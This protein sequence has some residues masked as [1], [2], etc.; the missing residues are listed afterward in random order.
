[1]RSLLAPA[2]DEQRVGYR[3]EVVLILLVVG[4]G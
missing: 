2:A 3:L 1:M 4:G